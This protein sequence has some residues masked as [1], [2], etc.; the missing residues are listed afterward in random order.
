MSHVECYLIKKLGVRVF[1]QYQGDDARQGSY[2]KR[3]PINIASRVGDDYYSEYTDEAKINRIKYYD[4][5]ASKIYALNPDLIHVL[6]SK[7]EFL[8]YSHISLMEWLPTYAGLS[9]GPLKIAHAPSHRG[10]KGTDLIINAVN[11]LKN[12]GFEFEFILIEGVGN[13]E[14]KIL[15]QNV[16]VIVD[17]LFAGWYGGLAVEAMALGKPVIAYIREED[18]KYIPLAMAEELPIVRAEPGSIYEIIKY[19]L[20]L[21]AENLNDISKKS[22]RYVE[23]WHDPVNIA[24]RIK[25]DMEDALRGGG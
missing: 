3:F 6:S 24:K 4:A 20:E 12:E 16:D 13:A 15:Y 14:A 23:R 22:R 17:Q 1:I 2:I 18:L 8:P 5:I 19:I 7:A 10:V 25:R 9:G 11:Q 21:S